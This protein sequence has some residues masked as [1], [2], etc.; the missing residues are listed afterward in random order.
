MEI[1][2]WLHENRTESR[3]TDAMNYAAENGLLNVVKWLHK[4]RTEG[5]TTYAMNDAARCGHLDMVKWLHENR[6]ECRTTDAMNY[7]ARDEYLDVVRLL[8]V[9]MILMMIAISLCQ[10]VCL[11]IPNDLHVCRSISPQPDMVK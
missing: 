6:T 2:K 11:N 4:N 5:C 1:V 3:T 10:G 9:M 8:Y 7:A